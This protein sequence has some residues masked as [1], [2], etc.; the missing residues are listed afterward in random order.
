MRVIITRVDAG[1]SRVRF[2]SDFGAAEAGWHGELPAV[3][4]AYDV[5]LDVDL[6][7]S[8][9]N[10]EPLLEH[11]ARSLTSSGGCIRL[12]ASVEQV[13]DD[14][15]LFLRMAPNAVLMIESRPESGFVCGQLLRVTLP[16]GALELTP[17]GGGTAS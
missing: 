11:E 15:M 3:G 2:R 8:S 4:E 13:D 5:E 10:A 1:L 7:L 17:I 6:E 9:A 14:G 16:E 12:V